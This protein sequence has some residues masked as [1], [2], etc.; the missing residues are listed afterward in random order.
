L[1]D[2][3]DMKWLNRICS[4][5]LMGFSG[6]IIIASLRVGVGSV[7]SPGPGFAGFLAAILLFVL[8]LAIFTRDLSTLGRRGEGKLSL[9]RQAVMK[10]VILAIT[11]CSYTF[12]LTTLGFLISTFILMFIMLLLSDPRRWVYHLVIA[13]LIVNVSYIL[14]YKWLGVILPSGIFNIRW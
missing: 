5:L 12:L 8:S 14:F 6:V 4:L 7:K 3:A 11:L 2:E 9:R 1:R 13:L 10:P